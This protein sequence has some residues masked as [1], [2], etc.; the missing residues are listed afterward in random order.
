MIDRLTEH[1][2]P[3]LLYSASLISAIAP[4][5]ENIEWGLKIA[6]SLSAIGFSVAGY[7]LHRRR[8]RRD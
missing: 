5:Q 6:A 2:T 3:G 8:A 1:T 4:W 7:L